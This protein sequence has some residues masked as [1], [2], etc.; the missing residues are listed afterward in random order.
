MTPKIG[1]HDLSP[2]ES[3][4]LNFN[5]QHARSLV[6]GLPPGDRGGGGGD[7]GPPAE[8]VAQPP[9]SGTAPDDTPLETILVFATDLLQVTSSKKNCVH[10]R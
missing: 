3:W 2:K 5:L 1:E 7:A 10:F 4:V 8:S 6:K 9:S